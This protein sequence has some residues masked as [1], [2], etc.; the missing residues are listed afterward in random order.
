MSEK[1]N[2]TNL[3]G[4][5]GFFAVA[6]PG[7]AASMFIPNRVASSLVALVWGVVAFLLVQWGLSR[8]ATEAPKWSTPESR[9]E[10]EETN[11]DAA[12]APLSARVR[13]KE[14]FSTGERITSYQPV[15]LSAPSI[16]DLLGEP[17]VSPP[18][19]VATEQRAASPL[20]SDS[21]PSFKPSAPDNVHVTQPL[22]AD[23]ILSEAS[24]APPRTPTPHPPAFDAFGGETLED[25]AL[26]AAPASVE[27]PEMATE[28]LDM[29][30][31]REFDSGSVLVPMEEVDF[32]D[33]QDEI[34]AV[35]APSPQPEL[36]L[37][38]RRAALVTRPFNTPANQ[39]SPTQPVD[40]TAFS[41]QLAREGLKGAASSEEA[42]VQV[43]A[44]IDQRSTQQIEDMPALLSSLLGDADRGDDNAHDALYE[45]EG[46]EDEDA[47]S[48]LENV[49][50]LMRQMEL[51]VGASDAAERQHP[52]MQVDWSEHG[53]LP[54]A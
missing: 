46:F 45:G 9:R 3:W 11:R 14:Q 30:D 20:V 5:I 12:I 35:T 6:A 38:E 2:N 10:E 48:R 26:L 27:R 24:L 31:F 16:D 32:G 40:M 17:A 54:D 53:G 29:A 50:S 41:K 43:Q 37:E 21:S 22:E 23:A 51:E 36:V 52:T 1:K 44:P 34:E 7:V 18:A 42:T 49:A 13:G 39:I 19:E 4:A 25:E 33:T 15:N 28:K 8:R 47:T